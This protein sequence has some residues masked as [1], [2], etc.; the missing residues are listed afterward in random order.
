MA[1]T[2]SSSSDPTLPSVSPPLFPTVRLA[3]LHAQHLTQDTR[4]KAYDS[5]NVFLRRLKHLY[6]SDIYNHT[7]IT[8]TYGDR[9]ARPTPF[10]ALTN[11]VLALQLLSNAEDSLY[12]VLVAEDAY[13]TPDHG[14]QVDEKELNACAHLMTEDN[15]NLGI[16]FGN[17]IWIPSLTEFFTKLYAPRM[18]KTTL[19]LQEIS[20]TQLESGSLNEQNIPP[21]VPLPQ[22]PYDA[23]VVCIGFLRAGI[24]DLYL[25]QSNKASMVINWEERSLSTVTNPYPEV[26]TA[27]ST[28]P[29]GQKR[30][31]D[32]K[33]RVTSISNSPAP[34]PITGTSNTR[35]HPRPKLARASTEPHF[36]AQGP[37][38]MPQER[39]NVSPIAE[40]RLNASIKVES[41]AQCH[42]HHA[43]SIQVNGHNNTVT[44]GDIHVNTQRP[45][46]LQ[47][48]ASF[49]VGGGSQP[50]QP[51]TAS[52]GLPN[53]GPCPSMKRNTAQVKTHDAS[54][55]FPMAG[56]SNY[57]Q[58]SWDQLKRLA[59]DHTT[60]TEGL[61]GY[62]S[63]NSLAFPMS[64]ELG[65]IEYPDIKGH[66]RG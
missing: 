63:Y 40:N 14:L 23:K 8:V 61:T 20:L 17:S 46:G 21:W 45:D 48:Q 31:L 5:A 6:S 38:N 19:R 64:E 28:G 55:S 15:V 43:P 58:D 3:L 11:A 4:D 12:A 37:R 27:Q 42:H 62:G 7:L 51:S 56:Y 52:A 24:A 60:I 34:I 2:A 53:P 26:G 25:P 36:T 13:A 22:W 41:S 47:P 65:G 32:Q 29:R 57:V 9:T 44:T 33:C 10:A 54:G 1:S 39:P 66:F 30:T 16:V 59:T 18:M 49:A 50:G 35:V